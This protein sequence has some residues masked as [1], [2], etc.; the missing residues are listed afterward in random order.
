MTKTPV[1]NAESVGPPSVPPLAADL[2]T[3]LRRLK[4][5]AVRLSAP[6]VLITAKTQRWTPEEVLRTLIERELVARDASN[7]VNRRKAAHS[8]THDVGVVRRGRL[9]DP[10]EGVRLPR[11]SGMDS[12]TTESGHDRAPPAAVSLTP[13]SDWEPPRSTPATKSATSAPPTSSK[14]STAVWP[15]TPSARSSNP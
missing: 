2:D 1:S 8:R 4:L 10:N 12:R 6:E 7:I 3:G 15:R 9:L 13:S 14:P 5:A 11:K